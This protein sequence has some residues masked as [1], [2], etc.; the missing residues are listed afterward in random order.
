M[1]SPALTRNDVNSDREPLQRV[2]PALSFGK[3]TW[4]SVKLENKSSVVQR[5]NIESFSSNGQLLEKVDVLLDPQ[6]TS[7]RKL[8]PRQKSIEMCWIR[9][10]HASQVAITVTVEVLNG[11]KIEYFERESVK[12][13]TGPQRW[14]DSSMARSGTF[15]YFLNL[16][17]EP[18]VLAFCQAQNS[19]SSCRAIKPRFGV[20]PNASIMIPVRS[21]KYPHLIVESYQSNAGIV[22]Y[23]HLGG[24][25]YREFKANSSITFGS[26]IK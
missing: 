13:N 4:T 12:P 21:G 1:E 14:V 11:N 2:Y 16:S 23:L 19:A 7:E 25:A 15:I 18:T 9:V 22:M 6:M 3:N 10:S 8:Q 26:E 5:V 20:N 17:K 24:E